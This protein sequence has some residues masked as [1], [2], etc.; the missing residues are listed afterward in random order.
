MLHESE[1][2]YAHYREYLDHGRVAF[3]WM[4]NLSGTP[5]A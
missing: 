3:V 4:Y 2:V 1:R 5:R